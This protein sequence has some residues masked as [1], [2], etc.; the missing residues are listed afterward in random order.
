[1]TL[2][3]EYYKRPVPNPSKMEAYELKEESL[4]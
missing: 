3:H 2:P 4:K 1:M